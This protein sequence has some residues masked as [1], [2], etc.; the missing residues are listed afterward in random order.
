MAILVICIVV[1][2]ASG[3]RFDHNSQTIQGLAFMSAP[4]SPELA[5]LDRVELS[6]YNLRQGE[7]WRAITPSFLHMSFAHIIF[8]MSWL[9]GLG[10]QIERREGARFFLLLVLLTA[11]VPNLLQG[12]MPL[13]WDGTP[14][15]VAD[16]RWLVPFGGFSGV[17]YGL[18][19]FA[20]VR[21]TQRMVPEYLLSPVAVMLAIG[22]LM[23]GILGLDATILRINMANW[24]HGGGLVIGMILAM[25]PLGRTAY[26]RP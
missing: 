18:F 22:W 2:V 15:G 17:A 13:D 4:R 25:L 5:G 19:G 11:A 6:S 14:P 24:G 20:W 21:G 9:V 8:N 23:L 10:F 26:R 1:F 12:L 7:I 16:D 3:F